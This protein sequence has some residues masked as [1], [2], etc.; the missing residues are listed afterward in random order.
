MHTPEPDLFRIVRRYAG[1]VRH[2]P[3]DE[4]P[5]DGR[6][7]TPTL[8]AVQVEKLLGYRH[9]VRPGS[10]RFLPGKH[11]LSGQNA[12]DRVRFRALDLHG[13]E[14]GGVVEATLGSGLGG[15]TRL[16]ID[17]R[18]DDGSGGP[19]G[20][21]AGPAH[22]VAR[23]LTGKILRLAADQAE[24]A[25]VETGDDNCTV[26]AHQIE[27]MVGLRQPVLPGTLRF[28]P[29]K[30]LDAV[31]FTVV[32][33]DGE[34]ITGTV[35]VKLISSERRIITFAD[36][37][38]DADAVW[39]DGTGRAKTSADTANEALAKIA[40]RARRLISVIQNARAVDKAAVLGGLARIVMIADEAK[41]G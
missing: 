3:I 23:R 7:D 38:V 24:A 28:T 12:V 15:T 25:I 37:H 36:V 26:P 32:G 41:Y 5:P 16:V 30:G 22:R 39:Q 21:R 31:R 4:T 35:S 8:S 2:A 9:P 27:Q 11:Y 40:A 13:T 6:R 33:E 18:V 29:G 17:L 34:N 19:E 20:R 14:V 10:L 1:E